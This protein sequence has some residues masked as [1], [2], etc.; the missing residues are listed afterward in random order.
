MAPVA[1][2][3]DATLHQVVDLLVQAGKHRIYV[4]G[5]AGSPVG[6]VTPTDVLRLVTARP[7]E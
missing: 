7:A 2:T 3:A 4:T 5:P 1:T 6:V